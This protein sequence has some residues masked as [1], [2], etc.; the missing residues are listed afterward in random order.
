MEEVSSMKSV[1]NLISY[2]HDFFRNFSQFLAIY[3]ELFSSGVNF[4]FWKTTDAWG[5]AVSGSVA[6]HRAL[7]SCWGRRRPNAPGGLKAAPTAPFGH[8]LSERTAVSP[9]RAAARARRPMPLSDRA[10]S[11]HRPDRHCPKPRRRPVRSRG[12]RV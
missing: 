7:I 12:R 4:L 2:F 3:F 11:P 10:A 6:P 5:P 8:P 1:P 9:S